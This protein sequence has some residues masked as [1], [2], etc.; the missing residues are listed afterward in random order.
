MAKSYK[1]IPRGGFSN[2]ITGGR[3]GGNFFDVN[4]FKKNGKIDY[5]KVERALRM[6]A[7]G[8]LGAK[9]MNM[10]PGDVSLDTIKKVYDAIRP[11][12]SMRA[13][14][15]TQIGMQEA[16][17]STPV[18]TG[19]EEVAFKTVDS[20]KNKL[21]GAAGYT[22]K[23]YRT[24]HT[25]GRRSTSTVKQ[26]ARLNGFEKGK[27]VDT[28]YDTEYSDGAQR[29]ALSLAT[30][31]NQKQVAVYRDMQVGVDD[32]YALY[33]MSGNYIRPEQK[34]ERVYGFM[35]SF[36]T[37]VQL[38]NVGSYFNSHVKVKIYRPTS[39][40]REAQPA[41]TSALPSATQFSND[42]GSDAIPLKY[43]MSGHTSVGG[44][45]EGKI[46]PKASLSY[47]PEFDRRFRHVKTF[48]KTLSPGD[49]FD[50]TYEV[51]CGAGIRLD[52]IFELDAS[53]PTAMLQ[54]LIIIEHNG[55]MCEGVKEQLDIESFIGTSPSWL[56]VRFEKGYDAVRG[57]L[58]SPDAY[59]T[60]GAQDQRFLVRSYVQ[61]DNDEGV[62]V[63]RANFDV[64]DIV[65]KGTGV[66]GQLY[67]PVITD[68]VVDY[69]QDRSNAN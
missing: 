44:R 20:V 53:E 68:S 39:N 46:D 36:Y 11:P 63:R 13:G 30:G 6:L 10:E 4:K 9:G 8:M 45:S 52:R 28:Q 61:K 65:D 47:S 29:Q 54:D 31:F 34:L 42:T 32:I 62:A 18:N 12:Q 40:L 26:Y 43:A 60:D 22:A 21:G 19:A 5:N 7:V 35:R 67:I 69:A 14:G 16:S 38:M 59:G 66:A 37:R 23:I 48:S 50:F 57:S 3:A 25:A 33:Q 17:G 2:K 58:S 51:Q 56:Q 41:I 49:M 55:V 1:K 15:R 27:F 24:H 64:T